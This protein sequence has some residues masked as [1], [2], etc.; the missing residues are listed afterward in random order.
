MKIVAFQV[1]NVKERKVSD[2]GCDR[3][4]ESEVLESETSDSGFLIIA[5]NSIPTA[6]R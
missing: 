3:S 2:V 5:Q 1:K 4:G 6:D